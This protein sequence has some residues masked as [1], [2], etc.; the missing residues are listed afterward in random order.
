MGTE[1]LIVGPLQVEQGQRRME[2]LQ[3]SLPGRTVDVPVIVIN[4]EGDGPRV[5]VT[6]GVHGAEYVGIEGARRLGASVDPDEVRG[7]LV[8]VPIVNTTAFYARSIYTSGLDDTNLNRVFPGREDG[9]ASEALA[10][11]IFRTVIAPSQYY[12][13]MHGGDMIE[14]L[15]PFVLYVRTGN[16]SVDE[17]ALAMARA[18]GIPRV[19]AGTTGGSTYAA[20]AAAGIPAILAEIGGQGVWSD[21]LAMQHEESTRR[22]LQSLGVLPG[23]PVETV[24]QRFYER[25]AWMRAEVDG[26][27]YPAV[28]VGDTVKEG[29]LV[30]SIADVFGTERQRLE[31]VAGGE[32]AFL[33]TSLA[34]NRG[35]PI[36]AVAAR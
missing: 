28:T 19:I 7:S 12:I 4:G 17:V 27:F 31:A 35:D 13:D 18:T 2:M 11:W 20:A 15:A 6:A 5:V 16:G 34:M 30:G 21:T 23:G 22:V 8:V 1:P 33:V 9:S 14:A 32:V 3:V 24:G 25:F 29:Q 36:L 10:G 26:L